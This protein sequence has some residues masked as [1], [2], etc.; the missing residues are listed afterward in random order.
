MNYLQLVQRLSR[1]AGVSGP[2]AGIATVSNTSGEAQ[3]LCDWVSQAWVEI[4]EEH[5][6][7]DWMR[8]SVT[9]NTVLNQQNYVPSGAEANLTDFARWKTNTFRAYITSVGIGSE[10]FVMPMNYEEFRDYYQFGARR[11]TYGRPISITVNPGDKALMLGPAP[12]QQYTMIGEYFKTVQNLSLD[13]DIPDMPDRFH[14][15]IVYRAMIHYGMFEA[16]PEAVQRG[17]NLYNEMLLRL[18]ADQLPQ[19]VT[20]G[21]L[22]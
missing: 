6:E 5:E 9:F 22:A 15:A 4:Q 21:P 12:D 18:E 13:A 1:E 14:M 10:M 3:R 17:E 2:S 19:I 8:K 7:W 20:A 11:Y 16:A